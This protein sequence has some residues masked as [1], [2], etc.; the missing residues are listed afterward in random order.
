M[1]KA[2]TQE[3]EGILDTN[4][5]N[6]RRKDRIVYVMLSLREGRSRERSVAGSD[7][8]IPLHGDEIATSSA[9]RRIPRNDPEGEFSRQ[10]IHFDSLQG[11]ASSI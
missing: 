6:L 7:E 10:A 8:A 5:K 3:S 11:G 4:R 2:F 1:K 9:S